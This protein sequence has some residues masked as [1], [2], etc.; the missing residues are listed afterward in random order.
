MKTTMINIDVHNI[1]E[2]KILEAKQ[3]ILNDQCVA[4]PTETVYGL[5]ANA[6]SP[7]AI[8]R[9]FEAKGR[10]SDNPLIVHVSDET[11]LLECIEQ[12]ITA[13]IRIIME[14]FWPGPLT[15]VFNK[16]KRIPE[17]VS[18]GLTTVGVRRPQHP[19]ALALIKAAGVPLAAPSANLSGRPS[20]TKANHVRDDL[21]GKIAAIIIADQSD[22][23]VESTVLD[24]SS[25]PFTVLRKGGISIE[26][27]QLIDSDIR[28]EDAEVKSNVTP[29]SPGQK[30]KHYAPSKPMVLLEGHLEHQLSY[31]KS[32]SLETTL[33]IS[34]DEII[35]KLQAP[36][37][38]SL[39]ASHDFK[40]A[41][42]RLFEILRESDSLPISSL[43]ITS[44]EEIGLGA[45]LNDRLRK[46]ASSTIHTP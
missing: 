45:T 41:M 22:V 31:L 2:S 23:G 44:F 35:Q 43:I 19:V 38:F 12:E 7:L 18:A 25:T 1:D 33:L 13:K 37:M 42:F 5:A 21:M 10:P 8:S 36:H 14:K 3:F 46:A 17:V 9:I 29:K 30:Y 24:V 4:M 39:G 32:I 16:S 15:L 11:M 28:Y 34:V 40:K 6:F 27:L 20:P 26:Q